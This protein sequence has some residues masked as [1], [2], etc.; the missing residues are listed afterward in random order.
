MASA[1]YTNGYNTGANKA[2]TYYRGR[3]NAI[4]VLFQNG[5]RAK[6]IDDLLAELVVDMSV[7][8]EHDATEDDLK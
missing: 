6:D 1:E 2:I 4:R 7:D 3:I 8:L 5:A